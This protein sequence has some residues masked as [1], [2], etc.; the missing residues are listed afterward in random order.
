[1]NL[2]GILDPNQPIPGTP[3]KT[4]GYDPDRKCGYLIMDDADYHNFGAVN[5]SVTSRRTLSEMHSQ[6]TAPARDTANMAI[7][8]LVDLALVSG[9]EHVKSKF[10]LFNA[11][12][13][14]TT[15]KPYK[16]DSDKYKNAYAIAAADAGGKFVVSLDQ[17]HEKYRPS[18]EEAVEAFKESAL[19]CQALQNCMLQVTG[20]MWH[21]VWE[22]W[23]K[24][25]P[26]AL[27]TAPEGLDGRD[28]WNIHDVKWTEHPLS[29]WKNVCYEIG[30]IHQA[31]WYGHNHQECLRK[32]GLKVTINSFNWL[33]VSA[34]DYDARRPRKAMARKICFPLDADVNPLALSFQKYMFP[35]D[36]MGRVE[37]FLSALKAWRAEGYNPERAIVRKVWPAYDHDEQPL[38]LVD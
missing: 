12:V 34:A 22:C 18:L 17:W 13:N 21:P 19:C 7:G 33:V 28:G 16:P 3:T 11:P 27:P 24:W 23:V 9:M 6:L 26:D 15:D 1:M 4:W 2:R 5:N 31:Q 8:T 14:P 30:H 25:K 37:M 10:K 29:R 20:I 38:Y 36:G 35:K 32:L